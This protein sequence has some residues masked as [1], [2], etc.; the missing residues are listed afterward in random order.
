MSTIGKLHGVSDQV[1]QDLP[2]PARITDHTPGRIRGEPHDQFQALLP[3]SCGEQLR[4]GFNR[5][6][7]VE[8]SRLNRHASRL[9]LGEVE[10]IVDDC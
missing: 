1:R 5:L 4:H 3:G 2:K 8:W 10:N 9:N 7:E 6:V